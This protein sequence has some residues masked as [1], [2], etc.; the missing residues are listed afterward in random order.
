M[1]PMGVTGGNTWPEGKSSAI[2]L[3]FDGGLPEHYELIAP[4]LEEHE[5]RGTFFVTVPSLLENP[6]AWKK[7]AAR[8][9]EIGSHSLFKV[10]ENGNLPAWTLEMVREDLRM[11]D[12]G[13]VEVLEAPVTA[14]AKPGLEAMAADGNYLT[15]LAK[16]FSFLR[17]A[18][19]TSNPVDS[20]D[21]MDIGVSHWSELIGPIESLLPAEKEWSVVAF[22]G[23][24]GA[25]NMAAEDDLRVLIGHAQRRSDVWIATISEIGTAIANQRAAV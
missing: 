12:K 6:E 3:T 16:Q 7:L 8:G 4:L 2:S 18:H 11:T 19:S 15:L 21:L 24:F 1:F 9:H 22:E 13:I 5:L 23:F 25:E 10:S 20:V 17:G 14:F